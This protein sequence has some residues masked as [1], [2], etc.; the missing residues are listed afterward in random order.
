MKNLTD[1][2]KKLLKDKIE[3]IKQAA[4]IFDKSDVCV[5]FKEVCQQFWLQFFDDCSYLREVG[6]LS[7]DCDTLALM[8]VNQLIIHAQIPSGST[9]IVMEALIG[10]INY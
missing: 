4:W 7:K 3:F 6:V 9:Q 8:L 1:D 2:E 10:Y 5:P